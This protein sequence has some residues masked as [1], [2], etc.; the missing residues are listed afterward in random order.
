LNFVGTFDA[1]RPVDGPGAHPNAQLHVD[2]VTTHAPPGAIIVPDA[3]LLF[4]GDFK[5]SGVDLILSKG[6]HELVLQ[7]YFKGEKRAALASPDGAHLSGDLVNTLAGHVDY[8]QA[9]GSA[10]AATVI[11]H[12]TKLLGT[13]TAIRNGVSIILNQGDNVHKGDVVQSGSDSTLGITFI[14]GTVFGLSSNAKMV[15]NEMVY[16]PNG[17][18]NSSLLSLVA[19]T[20]SFVAGETAKHGDM[21]VDTPVA[22]MGIRG[23]AVL[24]EIDFDVPQGGG[25]DAKFQVLVEPD[26]TTGSYIL[27]DKNTLAPIATVNQAGTQTVFSHGVVSFL[28]TAP[29]SPDVQKLINEVFTEKFTDNTNVNT[30]SLDHFTDTLLP[31]TF[32]PFILAN[33]AAAIPVFLNVA[34]AASA[35]PASSN[36]PGSSI[37]HISQ[38]PTVVTFGDST[39]E[40]AGLTHSGATDT[41]SG[42]IN[43]VD[44]NAGDLPTAKASFTSFTY[45]NAAHTD[46]TATLTA[47]QLKDI[48]LVEADLIVVAAPGNNNNGSATW[49][50]SVADSAF[51]FLAAGETLTLTYTAEVDSNFLPDNL[52]TLST[53]TITITGTNDAPVISTGPQT[54]AFS[55]GITTPGGDLSTNVPTQGT[56]A[57]T[58]VDLTDTHTVATKL[59][60]ISLVGAAV[61][62]A[63]LAIFENALSVSIA[64]DSTG[65]GNGTINWQLA[66]L[67]VYLADFIP[68]GETL[69]L[70][71]TVTLTD[72]QSASTTQD[73]IVKITGTGP[74]AVVWIATTSGTASGGLWGDPSNWETGAAPTATDDAIIIT[75]QL[76]GL[77]PSYPVTIAAPAFARSLT[78]NDFGTLFTNSP[79]LIN[80]STLT[81]GAGGIALEADSV[82]ENGSSTDGSAAISV[83]GLLEVLDQST[84]QNYG[85]ITLQDGGDFSGQSTVTNFSSG[86]IEVAGGTLNVLV[87]IANSGLIQIDSGAVLMVNGAA[88]GGGTVT[89]KANGTIDLTGNS[90]LQN[91]SLGNSGQINVTGIGN[92]LD[93]EIVTVNYALEV[94]AG[95]VLTLD[96]GTTV[97]NTGG[98]ITVDGTAT[99]TLNDASIDG[100]TINDD[101]AAGAGS[102]DITGSSTISNAD[103]NH[104]TVSLSGGVTLKLDGDTVTGTSFSEI[105]S[106]AVIQVDDGDML[107]LSGVTIDGVNVNDGTS[108]TGATIDVTGS[109]TI[110]NADLDNGT[111]AISGVTLTL[112]GDS[113]TGTSFS[114]SASG[115]VIQVDDGDTL[116]LS[117]VTIDGVNVN[118]GTTST[119]GTALD[120]STLALTGSTLIQ[121]GA[122]TNNGLFTVAGTG[123]ALDTEQVDNNA[124]LEILTGGSLTVDHGSV[125]TNGAGDTVQIDAG[126]K[127]TLNGATVTGGTVANT[128]GGTLDLAGGGIVKDGSLGNAGTTDVTG[129]GNALDHETVTVNYA[130]EVIAGGELTLDL[131]TT[132]ANGTITVDGALVTLNSDGTT[133]TIPAAA[134]TLN[135]AAITGGGLSNDGTVHVEGSV[136]ATLDDVSVTNSGT[137]QVDIST[138]PTGPLTTLTLDDGTKIAGG[139]LTIGSFGVLDITYGA[140]GAGATL[141]DGVSV[142]NSGIIQVD[143]GTTLTLN[144]AII[145]GGAIN[146]GTVAGGSVALTGLIDV[147]GASTIS[148]ASLN[149]GK[150]TVSGATLTL[151]SDTVTGTSFSGT[152][153]GAIIQV[154]A[155]DTLTLSGVAIDGVNIND[156]T[157][158]TGATI[159]V[160]ASSTI[161]NAELDNGTVAISGVT[162]TLDNDTVTGTSFSDTASGAIIQVDDSD[163]LTLSGVTITGIALSIGDGSTLDVEAGLQPIDSTVTLTTLTVTDTDGTVTVGSGATLDLVGASIDGGNLTNT[164]TIDNVSGSNSI[165]AV[166]TNTG[167]IE[168]E[169]GTLDLSGGL[170]GAGSLIIDAG[171]TLELAGADAQSVTFSG[172]IGT[173]QLDNALGFT[174]TI[175]AVSSAGGTFEITGPGSITTTSGDAIDFT[176]SGGI[177]GDA[178]DVTLTPAGALTGAANGIDVVQNGV[179]DLT[180][181][182]AGDVVGLVGD[183]VIAE[184]STTGSG[185]IVVDDSVSVTGT[186]SGSTGVL[187]ENLNA[188]NAGNISVTQLG[189]ASGGE[190]AISAITHGDG[191]VTVE[192]AGALTATADW[193]INAASYGSGDISVTTDAGS[194]IN[195]GGTGLLV[196]NLDSAIA[197]S[198]DSTIE[199][200]AYGTINS[201]T[202]PDPDG[203]IVGGIVAGYYGT[204]NVVE[205]VE[206]VANTNVNGTV[207][208]NNHANITAAAGYGIDAY[209]YGNGDVTVNDDAASVSGAQYGIA[210]Y[211]LSGGT[212]DVAVNV[213]EDATIAGTSIYGIEAVNFDVGDVRVS[214]AAGD[215][216]NSGSTGIDVNDQATSTSPTATVSLIVTANGTINSGSS[217]TLNG[218]SLSGIN[219]GYSGTGVD[220][221]V[222]VNSNATIVAAAG[223]GIN[224]YNSGIGD[225]TI[226]TGIQSSIS[227]PGSS[228]EANAFGGGNI[229]ITNDGTASGGI[230]ASAV[231]AGTIGVSNDGQVTAT[232]DAGVEIDQNSAGAT[233]SSKITNTGTIDST[234]SNAIFIQENATGTATIDNSGT[235]GPSVLS[236]TADAISES[237]GDITINNTGEITGTLNLANGTFNNETGG[238]WNATG[239]SGFGFLSTSG[240]LEAFTIDNAGTIDLSGA[241]LTGTDGLVIGNSGAIDSLSG[242]NIIDGAA[243]TNTGTFEVFAGSGLTL[244]LGSTVA[245][246]GHTITVDGAVTGADPVAAAMLLLEDGASIT[247]GALSLSSG[248]TLDIEHGPGGPGATLD[249]V[250]VT[251]TDANTG[252]DP[253]SPASTIEVGLGVTLTLDDGTKITGGM[254]TIGTGSTV[255]IAAGSTDISATL[256]G[257]SVT[258]SG[259]ILIGNVTVP[260]QDPTLTLD[261][262]T[263]VTGGTLSIG[264][265]DTLDIEHGAHGSG[266]TLDGVT[267]NATDSTGTIKVGVN[268][269]ATLL[270]DDGTSITDGALSIG[271]GSTLDVENDANGLGV[272]LDGV[273]VTGVDAGAGPTPTPA[274]T[275]EIGISG[276]GTLTLDDGTSITGGAMTIGSQG[277]LDISHGTVTLDDIVVSNSGKIQVDD[278]QTLTLNGTT[279]NGG[280]IND[281]STVAGGGIIDVAG[282]STIAG[283][284]AADADLTGAGAFS[285]KVT[286]DAALT[287]DYVKLNDVSIEKGT[288]GALT[289]EDTV[290]VAGAVKL[291]NDTVTNS[292][293][294]QVDD[295]QTLTLSGTTINGTI[296][297][298]STVTGGGIIDVTGASTIAGTSTT[299]ANLT[300][301]GG[302]TSKVTLDAALTLDYVKL[303]D[304]SIEKGTSGALT[305][306]DTVE[307]AGA[308]K[309]LNDT[310]IN[311]GTLQVDDGQTLTLSGTTINGTVNDFSTVTGGGIIDVIGASTIAGT[312]A[313]DANLTGAGAF[314]SKV[315]LDAALTLDYVKLNDVSI[316]KGTSGALTIKDTVEVAGSVKLLNDTVTNSGTLQIDDGQ[317][318]T[319]SGT[320]IIGGI[321]NDGTPSG[322]GGTIDVTGSSTIAGTSLNNGNVTIESGKTLT[323]DNDTVTG[324]TFDDTA[325]GSII[326]IDSGTTLT[327]GS[328]T[329]VNGGTINISGNGTLEIE[330]SSGATLNGVSIT[331]TGTMKIDDPAV[332]SI[333]VLAGGTSMTG[334]TLT[335]GSA[336]TLEIDTAPG[337]TLNDVRIINDHV[338]E[339][340]AGSVLT[341]DLGTTVANAGSTINIDAASGSVATLELNGAA[342]NGGTIN[343]N[344][345]IDVTGS[346]SIN[347]V[348]T[349]FQTTNA[350]LNG[351]SVAVGSGVILT[352]D[353]VTVTDTTFTDSGSIKLDDN[354]KLVLNGVTI[355]GGT[356]NDSGTVDV[357]GDSSINGITTNAVTTN[358]ILNNGRVTVESGEVLTLDDVTANGTTF[359]DAAATLAVVDTLVLNGVAIHGGIISDGG[360]IDVTG[361][362][363]IYGITSFFGF[364]S[365]TNA[366]LNG[367]KV[368]VESGKILT[369]DN[370]TVNSSTFNNRGALQI[371]S[372]AILMLAGID[373]IAGIAG[374]SIANAGTIDVTG[375]TT[376][377]TDSLTDT[378]TLKVDG[379][380]TLVH[381]AITGGTITDNGTI[382]VTF[383]SSIDGTTTNAS[384]NG[385]KVTIE[386]GVT[387]TLDNDTVGSTK[388]TDAGT[389]HVDAGKAL[390]LDNVT[391]TGGAITDAGGIQVDSGKTLTL[392]NVTMTGGTIADH[393]TI[394][395]DSGD[396]LTLDD[397][398]VTGGR[399]A[400][401][402]TIHVDGGDELTLDNVTV[403]GGAITNNGTINVDSGDKL[404]LNDV[405]ISGGTINDN[406]IIVIT[407]GTTIGNNN[408][409]NNNTAIHGTAVFEIDASA[410]NEELAHFGVTDTFAFNFANVGHD[411]VSHFDTAHDT[412][413]FSS[414]IFANAAAALNATHEVNGDAVITLDSHDTIT[415]VGVHVQ[416]LHQSDFNIV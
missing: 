34:A 356:I 213:G 132:V 171:A 335:I 369:L 222:T 8:A 46:V 377:N 359:N 354:R 55:G 399:I 63:P 105:A 386:S 189:G 211:G 289:I 70:T 269:A 305:I 154:D 21:K 306:D 72:S 258:N 296:N 278:G 292:G 178:A 309:L 375:T 48:A 161:S 100:G 315:T 344:G 146:D 12:V 260:A 41:A 273:K 223:V 96:L 47:L 11:G 135:S 40:R 200:T 248:S 169:A 24:V 95:G 383:D 7:D 124:T 117:G 390:T 133:T 27:F 67:P 370:V 283:T 204:P 303:N 160:T 297:D 346:S 353:D 179:G 410:Q 42:K 271:S 122:L 281:F 393:G 225:I 290:E 14:D 73:V 157:S 343:D 79:T 94:M 364:G 320:E 371:D 275:I 175:T 263:A 88:I 300:G 134:L 176:A 267:V 232:F 322:I 83:G 141:D 368:T 349:L 59:T 26:G 19:G 413:Q 128:A 17:S 51:D 233:G 249:G 318:L 379:T 137:I 416:N 183:G 37:Q 294:L 307:V 348:T 158:S 6:D 321:I 236:T 208:V 234:N 331:G 384:L 140:A 57:F 5:R 328:G 407:G 110:S 22:T 182:P 138:I 406:G 198:A 246:T 116:A 266:A 360:I 259:A 363:S 217:P 240:P 405:S 209:N 149:N 358:A 44:V 115:A 247:S 334:G 52:A 243:I 365:T 355:N 69:T 97:A 65:T 345:A 414:S 362:S 192:S 13:A 123:N 252:T 412:L 66:D 181:K 274:S 29:L 235:I 108:S 219:A 92:A 391:V 174:G 324:T 113:V 279:I 118:D 351:G 84:L 120:N 280:T 366:V 103:L 392:D 380:L 131:G 119:G 194:L 389:V 77:T 261:D 28:T 201:G 147:T 302:F 49:T 231:D 230:Y 385:G 86:T 68:D 311:S 327:L 304:V 186:G 130:L 403:T 20:I 361:N 190:N 199:V 340:L 341:L 195:S 98:A 114:E 214:T 277:V 60:G 196:T 1:N 326:Q 228:I 106:G 251:G 184:D 32:T 396:K 221:N 151:D 336:G 36:G 159:D 325:S 317:T 136:G 87:D 145:D 188:A 64:T 316:E 239:S 287:L 402:G 284:R 203:E 187:A 107:T 372:D 367:G 3:H 301:A 50:Y 53:F 89:N 93:H 111:V 229:T 308:V 250:A 31:Q 71:Y 39:T 61:P 312:S 155:N 75:D 112:D 242:E 90:A 153:S 104:G 238:T 127:L 2:S 164:G 376:L 139:Q 30:K 404:T 85:Q 109:T 415:L 244:D 185:N 237:G 253:T 314:T 162:L 330:A 313:A 168:V 152:A 207:V 381:T 25:P 270:L 144:G 18:N 272:A 319:L 347:G 143:D 388:F 409:N 148:D 215:I 173:L 163:K 170:S 43:F 142:G 395:V 257:V 62:P 121:S 74:P 338:I 82:V 295:G 54:V 129:T 80:Q 411:T 172:G 333:L 78:M 23:T 197:A 350:A 218:G 76:I 167:T 298:F 33:G 15:L 150:V 81:V 165:S 323:L 35:T 216:I 285:S 227:A 166:V 286:L 337:A 255:E 374:S 4:T 342:V 387:L 291:L 357:T 268:G 206:A 226:T 156:G 378:G 264:S 329:T 125:V 265:G 16:D 382:D 400:N 180:I 282:A 220:D 193:A 408:N 191:N 56:L 254:L 293:T 126:G 288:S 397:V 394:N 10:S 310:I 9:D 91:G 256:D 212:G 276:A 401:S 245:N 205:G 177:L 224:A 38:A 45:Q 352:L 373:L 398:T 299:D 58:D 102:I 332:S 339:V 210:A 99:L 241:T 202:T 101:S 262:G